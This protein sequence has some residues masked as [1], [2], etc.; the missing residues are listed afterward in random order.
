MITHDKD[1]DIY[2]CVPLMHDL[3]RLINKNINNNTFIHLNNELW[4][5]LYGIANSMIANSMRASV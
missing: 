3:S 1:L 5:P 2:S 4:N